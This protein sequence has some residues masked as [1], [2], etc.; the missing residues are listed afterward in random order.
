MCKNV[1][2]DQKT[3]E[4]ASIKARLILVILV[5]LVLKKGIED[6]RRKRN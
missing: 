2:I 4:R 6:H 3:A 1:K 5:I